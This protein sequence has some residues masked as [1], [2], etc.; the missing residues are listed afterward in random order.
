MEGS[1]RRCGRKR[2]VEGISRFVKKRC[3]EFCNPLNLRLNGRD[4]HNEPDRMVY[5]T[6]QSSQDLIVSELTGK[7][8]E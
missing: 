6:S 3:A 2:E 1:G 4:P 8:T 7:V 5:I